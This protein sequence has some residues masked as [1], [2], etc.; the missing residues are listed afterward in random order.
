MSFNDVP[1]PEMVGKSAAVTKTF[2]PEKYTYLLSLLPTPQSYGELHDRFEASYAASLKGDPAKVKACEADR[3]AI[4]K[5]LSILLGVAKAAAQRPKRAGGTR[6]RFPNRK[7]GRLG[8][9]LDG[10]PRVQSRLYPQRADQRF[11]RTS[12]GCKGLSDLALRQRPKP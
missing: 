9:R 10:A 6:T 8:R 3:L 11:G 12:R 4:N 1:D 5:N 7:N 2:T